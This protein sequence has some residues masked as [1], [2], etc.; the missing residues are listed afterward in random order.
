MAAEI[1][2]REKCGQEQ[3]VLHFQGGFCQAK[4]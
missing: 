1:Q 2:Q 4:Q 3:R